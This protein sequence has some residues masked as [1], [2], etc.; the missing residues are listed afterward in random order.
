MKL[1]HVLQIVV[2]DRRLRDVGLDKGKYVVARRDEP[3]WKPACGLFKMFLV[4]KDGEQTDFA[5]Y[6]REYAIIAGPF[7]TAE[8]ARSRVQ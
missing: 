1:Y 6:P 4:K 7:H 3:Q 5:V 2:E 8:E